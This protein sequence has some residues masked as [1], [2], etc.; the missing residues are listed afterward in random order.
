MVRAIIEPDDS[1]VKQSGDLD[2]FPERTKLEVEKLGTADIVVGIP[3]YNN[4][5]TIGHVVRAAQAGLTKYFH[6]YKSVIV[7][8]DGGSKDGTPEHVLEAHLEETA[9]LQAPYQIH[10][11]HRLSTP[12]HGIPGKGSAFRSTFLLAERLD[13]KACA[14]VDSDLRS[15]TPEWIELLVRPVLE[16]EFDFVAPYYHRHKYDG[17]ITNSIVYPMTRALYGKRIRQPIGGDFGFSSRLIDHYLKQDVWD[18]DVARFGVDIWVTTQAI[19]GGFKLCQAFLGAKIH[20]PK[21]P[22]SDLSAMLAQVLGSLFTEMER[23]VD[24]WQSTNGSAATPVFGF[25]FEVATEPVAVNVK[26][27]LESFRL[28]YQT[29]Q[30][31]WGPIL[32]PTTLSELEKRAG[33]SDEQFQFPDELWART[34][35]DFALGHHLRLI[36]RD[37]LLRALTPLYLGWV[38]SFIVEMQNAGP[39][40]VEE[41]LERLCLT[42]EAQK[43][44]LISRWASQNRSNA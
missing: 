31:I 35:Y 38:A 29:L 30:E 34:V 4:A 28:G 33:L 25:R 24:V 19:C 39:R 20:D 27:M 21:D 42:Y 9:L 40:E 37:H 8:S 44:Y 23:N 12:Y 18:S 14:V 16:K 13:A 36:G 26:R 43:P 7:N 1:D 10:P 17:T 32:P 22:G 15:I 41:R 11:V 3:S 5:G 6:S 2:T